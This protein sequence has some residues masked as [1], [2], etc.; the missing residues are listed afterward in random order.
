MLKGRG[1][2]QRIFSLKDEF[3]RSARWFWEGGGID[4]TRPLAVKANGADCGVS[5]MRIGEWSTV[6]C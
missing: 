4:G 6:R 5:A 1:I 2:G 3:R